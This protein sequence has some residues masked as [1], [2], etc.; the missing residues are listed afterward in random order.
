MQIYADKFLLYRNF[1]LQLLFIMMC[2]QTLQYVIFIIYPVF[3][4]VEIKYM[5]FYM[6]DPL[7]IYMHFEKKIFFIEI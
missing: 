3:F 1:V 4:I 7:K 2:L 5:S 6:H